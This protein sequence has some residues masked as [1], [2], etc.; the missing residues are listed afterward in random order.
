M[1]RRRSSTRRRGH[2]GRNSPDPVAFVPPASNLRRVLLEGQVRSDGRPACRDGRRVATECRCLAKVSA[3]RSTR[4]LSAA[5]RDTGVAARSIPAETHEGPHKAGLRR[6]TY[7]DGLNRRA[8][9]P[10]RDRARPRPD[11]ARA[12]AR[13]AGRRPCR[14][15]ASPRSPAPRP[16]TACAGAW[17]WCRSCQ[18]PSSNTTSRLAVSV[19]SPGET[20]GALSWAIARIAIIGRTGW[21]PPPSLM[22][23]I[24]RTR[25]PS[26]AA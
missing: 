4:A 24:R 1:A 12:R 22:L 11:P 25:M 8:W 16:S 18:R 17:S 15:G 19:V 7:G 3:R 21:K 5:S 2:R 23:T 9:S 10:D 26:D 6:Q 13:A 20:G 14:A